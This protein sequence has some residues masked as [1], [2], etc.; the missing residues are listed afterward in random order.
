LR[1]QFG[2]P[3]SEAPAED[4]GIFVEDVDVLG[5]EAVLEG[6]AGGFSLGDE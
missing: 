6:V 3:L 5:A 1:V 4:L 2:A